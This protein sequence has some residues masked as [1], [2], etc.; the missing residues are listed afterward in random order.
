MTNCNSQNFDALLLKARNGD[1]LAAHDLAVAYEDGNNVVQDYSQAFMWHMRSADGGN[2][3]SIFR[4]GRI[5]HFG[6]VG[7]VNYEEAVRWYQ[8]AIV[9]GHLLA[10][11]NLGRM[12]VAGEGVEQNYKAA[13]ALFKEAGLE[14]DRDAQNNLGCLYLGE[15]GI[16]RDEVEAARW[17]ELSANQGNQKAQ[18]SLGIMYKDGMGIAQDYEKAYRLLHASALQG[19]DAAQFHLGIMLVTGNGVPENQERGFEWLKASA[20]HGN[21]LAIEA[22]AVLEEERNCIPEPPPEEFSFT[23]KPMVE[24]LE[25]G[26][27][28]LWITVEELQWS[29]MS[30]VILGGLMCERQELESPTNTLTASGVISQGFYE[31]LKSRGVPEAVSASPNAKLVPGDVVTIDWRV[32][33]NPNQFFSGFWRMTYQASPDGLGYKYLGGLTDY[34]YGEDQSMK[35]LVKS[36][37]LSLVEKSSIDEEL[38]TFYCETIET[39]FN[40]QISIR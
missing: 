31:I 3:D 38:K 27:R 37:K 14:G 6:L 9:D 18:L 4:L 34:F 2:A 32:Q 33:T 25:G 24:T 8:R 39:D 20:D 12:Y 29:A 7:E 30:N 22:I 10:K 19:D 26:S 40:Q 36:A 21:E 16:E 28:S 11:V 15:L 17:F 23:L 35:D 13:E 5:Y 1:V